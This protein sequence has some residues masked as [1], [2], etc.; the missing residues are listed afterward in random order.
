MGTLAVAVSLITLVSAQAQTQTQLDGKE[1][2]SYRTVSYS[3]FYFLH[4]KPSWDRSP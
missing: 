4:H 1:N 2:I 3:F